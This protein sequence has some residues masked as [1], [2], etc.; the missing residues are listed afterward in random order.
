MS[1]ESTRSRSH[2]ISCPGSTSSRCA[3]A[4]RIFSAMVMG[5][6][7]LTPSFVQLNRLY[8]PAHCSTPLKLLSSTARKM[9]NAARREKAHGGEGSWRGKGRRKAARSGKARGLTGKRAREAARGKGKALGRRE[10]RPRE[11]CDEARGAS[12][13]LVIY[14]VDTCWRPADHREE[15]SPPPRCSPRC[16]GG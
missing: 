11:P 12:M 3:W 15:G 6:A 5:R 10:N 16:L 14:S 13:L 4:A 7:M 8:K 1:L 9:Q 2:S